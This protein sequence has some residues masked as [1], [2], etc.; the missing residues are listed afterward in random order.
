[1][2]SVSR[3]VRSGAPEELLGLALDVRANAAHAAAPTVVPTNA[4]R[5]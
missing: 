1:M 4:R 2:P 3:L 5:A